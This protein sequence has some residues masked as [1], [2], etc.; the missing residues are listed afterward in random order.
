MNEGS[1][2][3]D[4]PDPPKATS[5]TGASTN[6]SGEEMD[7]ET[8]KLIDEMLAEE[9]Q[10]MIQEEEE[11]ERKQAI[12]LQRQR[13]LEQLL[14]ERDLENRKKLERKKAKKSDSDSDS[15]GEE[16]SSEEDMLDKFK[17]KLHNFFKKEGDKKQEEQA[18]VVQP[19]PAVEETSYMDMIDDPQGVVEEFTFSLP[20]SYISI[21]SLRSDGSGKKESTSLAE[22]DEEFELLESPPKT[23]PNYQVHSLKTQKI[24]ELHKLKNEIQTGWARKDIMGDLE[25]EQDKKEEEKPQEWNDKLKS[26]FT[27]FKQSMNKKLESRRSDSPDM[28]DKMKEKFK[29]NSEKAAQKMKENKEQAAQKMKEVSEK[30]SMKIKSFF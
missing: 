7:S 2:L 4:P 23:K 8:Q 20:K 16:E 1:S 26:S 15:E 13:K 10:L 24:G 30:F 9:A 25:L 28:A 5:S 11:E 27:E 18:P 3:V 14:L 19:Q 12:E 6:P 17:D 29:E 21:D 22:E